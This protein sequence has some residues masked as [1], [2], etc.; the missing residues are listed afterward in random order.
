[1]AKR[2]VCLFIGVIGASLYRG[3]AF[4]EIIGFLTLPP[5]DKSK[6]IAGAGSG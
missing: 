1:M 2:V 4:F 5:P 6:A 3:K